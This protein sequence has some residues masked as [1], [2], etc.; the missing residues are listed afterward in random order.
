M[1]NRSVLQNLTESREA[2][3]ARTARDKDDTW[4]AREKL[5]QDQ[6]ALR[7]SEL[8]L[9]K[10]KQMLE[11]VK[12]KQL[13]RY[14][15]LMREVEQKQQAVERT[16]HE[17]RIQAEKLAAERE[18]LRDD[19][20][21][22]KDMQQAIEGRNEDSEK[23]LR[24]LK[25]ER[26][27]WNRHVAETSSRL[28]TEA[29]TL[30]QRRQALRE[31]AE[32]QDIL[33]KAEQE[34]L[35]AMRRQH[36]QAMEQVEQ[37][38]QGLELREKQAQMKSEELSR[39]LLNVVE[40][41]REQ[42]SGGTTGAARATPPPAS[43][44]PGRGSPAP[45]P[46]PTG[47]KDVAA[48]L[49]ALQAREKEYYVNIERLGA[50]QSE[51][52]AQLEQGK[53]YSV[54]MRKRVAAEEAMLA[55]RAEE[56][57]TA[58][59]RITEEW[60]R[61]RSEASEQAERQRELDERERLLREM[62]A[63]ESPDNEEEVERLTELT[64][65]LAQAVGQLHEV[66]SDEAARLKADFEDE[67]AQWRAVETSLKAMLASER[68]S[69][70]AQAATGVSQEQ[71][72]TSAALRKRVQ[73]LEKV[74]DELAMKLEHFYSQKS[75][76]VVKQLE[77]KE[78]EMEA[79]RQRM[80]ER[81]QQEHD[82]ALRT[83]EKTIELKEAEARLA[84]RE[85]EVQDQFTTLEQER[86]RMAEA[87]QKAVEQR[88]GWEE[89]NQKV[90]EEQAAERLKACV[91]REKDL[92]ERSEVLEEK[93]VAL[94][95]KQE[96][97]T[98]F[99]SEIEVQQQRNHEARNQLEVQAAEVAHAR[100][101]LQQEVEELDYQTVQSRQLQEDLERT[102][103]ELRLR[104]LDLNETAKEVQDREQRV[105]GE[106]LREVEYTRMQEVLKQKEEVVNDLL[107]RR[108]QAE[109]QSWELHQRV[110][111]LAADAQQAGALRVENDDL[112]AELQE[113][114]T[115]LTK[116]NQE[117]KDSKSKLH[118]LQS[119]AAELDAKR[120]Q[121]QQLEES[122]GSAR[123]DGDAFQDINQDIDK[124]LSDLAEKEGQLTTREAELSSREVDLEMER[125]EMEAR[126]AK[127]AASQLAQDEQRKA[128]RL[129]EL[130]SEL[131]QEQARCRAEHTDL[132][133]LRYQLQ[134]AQ[135]A[136]NEREA[137]LTAAGTQ[138]G[139]VPVAELVAGRQGDLA[140]LRAVEAERDVLVDKLF[141]LQK[142]VTEGAVNVG[143]SPVE[144]PLIL[145]LSSLGD[146]STM[147]SAPV[148]DISRKYTVGEIREHL[149]SFLKEVDQ[150]S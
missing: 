21:M 133:A 13:S 26:E 141:Q 98:L 134:L 56:Q 44:P 76:Q 117:S 28:K 129:D 140:K 18:R 14:E 70:L 135:D 119:Q 147:V 78:R 3:L 30:E 10:E 11:D 8:Q 39:R 80:R 59:A 54:E 106:Y 92:Q 69:A 88:L 111:S 52:A 115:S 75:S 131:E 17:E 95:T 150:H 112:K 23:T 73:A 97:L 132:Q 128:S 36:Q 9:L 58:T 24:K 137:A 91:R 138:D 27:E 110:A 63:P 121:L 61:L 60:D 38:K 100:E 5:F 84:A 34:T 50:A 127:E 124:R 2:A 57:A 41:E 1:S 62:G 93:F 113:L 126:V 96:Q 68:A 107:A 53:L 86:H 123:R 109:S 74:N 144:I 40:A 103:T 83:R 16:A 29:D 35:A 66:P 130:I 48:Q 102:R 6:E 15:N 45:R 125:R 90:L 42:A 87:Q 139:A 116:V 46:L 72:D 4:A 101:K 81:E 77:E 82:L 20:A 71:V 55:Q 47:D 122:L 99:A 67:R 114:R 148:F 49:A 94:V 105:Q 89:A 7:L 149:E 145:D 25:A 64:A 31:D 108:D 104:E 43:P 118:Q 146:A 51:L 19:R 142:S 32:K 85:K 136:L 120:R 37:M 22:V 12:T 143:T 33:M 65:Q 79:N